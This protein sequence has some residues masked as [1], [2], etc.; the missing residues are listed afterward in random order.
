MDFGP[1]TATFLILLLIGVAGAYFIG[2]A[3]DG[4]LGSDGFG[5]YLNTMILIAG[6]FLGYHLSHRIYLPISGSTYQAMMVVTGAF[7]SLAFLAIFKNMAR[8][9]GF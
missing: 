7:L 1:E 8:R 3:M 2:V 9:L 6:G 5:V 4:V